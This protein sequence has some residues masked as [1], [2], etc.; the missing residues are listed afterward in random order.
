MAGDLRELLDQARQQLQPRNR[1][2]LQQALRD[3]RAGIQDMLGP[4]HAIKYSEGQTIPAD[5]PWLAIFPA[6]SAADPTT[7]YYVVYLFAADG[8]AVNLCVG[9][10]TSQVGTE[11]ALNAR[12]SALQSAIGSVPGRGERPVLNSGTEN[13]RRYSLGTAACITYA[14][15]LPTAP[16][17]REDLMRYV[18]AVDAAHAQG[19]RFMTSTNPSI[20]FSPG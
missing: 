19:L 15:P 2:A 9:L 5:I 4:G 17:L 7:G 14:Q 20:S 11:A 16:V 10:G 8:S 13:A 18:A 1:P 12:R 3:L 6:D